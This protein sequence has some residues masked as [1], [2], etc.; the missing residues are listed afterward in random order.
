VTL[1]DC[2]EKNSNLLQDETN[3]RILFDNWVDKLETLDPKFGLNWRDRKSNK[4]VP[5]QRKIFRL[6][7][8][9]N[10]EGRGKTSTNVEKSS[11]GVTKHLPKHKSLAG[12]GNAGSLKGLGPAG[13]SKSSTMLNVRRKKSPTVETK[14]CLKELD[15]FGT[16]RETTDKK[17]LIDALKCLSEELKKWR[18]S[19]PGN[20]DGVNPSPVRASRPLKLPKLTQSL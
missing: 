7:S 11:T 17:V 6:K 10:E 19:S 18:S 1:I 9:S 2:I 15:M 12:T 14:A 13:D 16:V 20:D 3:L 5:G 8:W 4:K